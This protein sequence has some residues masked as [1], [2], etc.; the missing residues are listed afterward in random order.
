MPAPRG[1]AWLLAGAMLLAWG[2]HAQEALQ[3]EDAWI[4]AAPPGVSTTAGYMVLRNSG[5]ATITLTGA[6]SPDFGRLMLHRTVI[7]EGQARMVHQMAIPIAP[8]E[9]VAFEPGGYHIMLMQPRKRFEAGDRVSV[10]LR[11]EGH[12]PLVLEVPVRKN[13]P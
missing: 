3:V 5:P 10:T 8:G 13:P 2:A 4:R 11:F 6:E 7:E 12:E 1:W 9:S